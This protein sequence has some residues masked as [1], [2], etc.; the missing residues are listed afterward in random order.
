[1][2]RGR[3]V[4]MGEVKWCVIGGMRWAGLECKIRQWAGA[5]GGVFR[6]RQGAPGEL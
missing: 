5:R 6:T 3:G 2:R 4:R 1:M